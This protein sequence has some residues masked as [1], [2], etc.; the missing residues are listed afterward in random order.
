M[1]GPPVQQQA[2]EYRHNHPLDPRDVVRVFLA[3]GL[4]RPTDDLPRITRML[5]GANLVVSAWHADRLIGVCRALTDHGW[6]CYVS[7]LAVD[8]G[9]QRRGIGA[10][11]IRRVR[12]V[13]GDGVSL[14]LLSVPGAT[15]YYPKIGFELADNAFVLERRP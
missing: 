6:C 3:S 13:L 11:M 8:S 4:A 12:E 7:E 15:A 5:A 14:I 10:S 9:F 1:R 2:I